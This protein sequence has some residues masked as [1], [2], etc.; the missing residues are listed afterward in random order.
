MRTKH[1]LKILVIGVLVWLI[2]ILAYALVEPRNVNRETDWKFNG[3]LESSGGFK[4]SDGDYVLTAQEV[5]I[6]SPST[7]FS[8][9]GAYRIELTSDQNVTGVYPIGGVVDQVIIIEPGAGSNTIQF[10]NG[11]TTTLNGANVILT[12]GTTDTLT[13]ICIDASGPRWKTYEKTTFTGNAA[14]AT[15]ATLASTVTA[16]ADNATTEAYMVFTVGATGAQAPKTDTGVRY[17]ASANAITVAT[18]IAALTGNAD[19]A[20]VATNVT[21]SNDATT[22]EAYVAFFD[23][24]TGSQGPATNAELRFNGATGAL[25]AKSLNINGT[26]VTASA[27][28]LNLV[29]GFTLIQAGQLTV[30]NG[31]TSNTAVISGLLPEAYVVATFGEAPTAA[32]HCW[33]VPSTDSLKIDINANNT[34]NLKINYVILQK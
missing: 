1:A 15:L 31:D 21:A 11:T 28:E 26:A 29:D 8:A 4:I 24:A 12:E 33:A 17:N 2:A 7:T 16:A 25:R 27:T 22:T 14:T 20:T 13:L 23:G 19:S 5:E 18:V 9:A 34:A 32:T 30:A 10:D 3:V 6:T